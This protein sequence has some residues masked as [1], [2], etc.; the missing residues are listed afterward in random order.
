MASPVVRVRLL[1][2]S[3]AATVVLSSCGTSVDSSNAAAAGAASVWPLRTGQV[4]D[5]SRVA[6]LARKLWPAPDF[7]F[8]LELQT[9]ARPYGLTVTMRHV[10]KP[11]ETVNFS[12]Q[13][14]LLLGLVGNLDNV[15]I[16]DASGHQVSVLTTAAASERI[17]HDVKDF[18]R[19]EASLADYLRTQAD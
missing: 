12:V 1:V 3:L 7:T 6:A 8:T 5:S 4:G 18:G 17:G 11:I 19:D 15:A 14:T 13:M 10:A 16:T 9:A 2:A